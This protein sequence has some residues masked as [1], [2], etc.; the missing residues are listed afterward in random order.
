VYFFVGEL[1]SDSGVKNFEDFGEGA[2]V[3]P[4]PQFSLR[5]MSIEGR[6][7][8]EGAK[9]RVIGRKDGRKMK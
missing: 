9:E 2:G 8:R 7:R 6:R 1:F 5:W 4:N 3:T